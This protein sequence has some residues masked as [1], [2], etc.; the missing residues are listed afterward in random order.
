METQILVMCIICGQLSPMTGNVEWFG[1]DRIFYADDFKCD[2]CELHL[3]G[4][5]EIRM[6]GMQ[7]SYELHNPFELNQ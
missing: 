2:Q 7:V 4:S 1:A 6:S 3:E 5:D